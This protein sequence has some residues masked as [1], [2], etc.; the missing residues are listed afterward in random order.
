MPFSS[1]QVCYFINNFI[2]CI[3]PFYGIIKILI[4]NAF[5]QLDMFL[6]FDMV[7]SI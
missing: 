1:M 7:V 3:F 5:N 4:Y 6:C 2:Y